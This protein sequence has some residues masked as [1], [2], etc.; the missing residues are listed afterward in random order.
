[1]SNN[2]QNKRHDAIWRERNAQK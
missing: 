2:I 1:M